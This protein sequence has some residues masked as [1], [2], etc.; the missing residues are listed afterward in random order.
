MPAWTGPRNIKKLNQGAPR[1]LV[2]NYGEKGYRLT[3]EIVYPI[4]LLKQGRIPDYVI[5]CDGI[6]EVMVG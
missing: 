6:N 2:T 3:Q 5:F 4:L 1:Y